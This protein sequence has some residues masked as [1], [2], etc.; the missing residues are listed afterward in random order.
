M[1]KFISIFLCLVLCAS[2]ALAEVDLSGMSFDELV[3]LKAQINLAIWM[4]QEWQEVTVPQGM[5][6]IGVDI[7]AGHWTLIANKSAYV[8]LGYGN[9]LDESGKD[10]SFRGSIYELDTI[11]GED[12]WAY[13]ENSKN[14]TDFVL[15]DGCYLLIDGGSVIFTPYTGKPSL[16]FK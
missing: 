12:N 13:D 2:M 15:K 9:Q 8:M 14:Q 6:E 1:K 4:S 5:W 10:L 11:I 7:P 3:K 16:G